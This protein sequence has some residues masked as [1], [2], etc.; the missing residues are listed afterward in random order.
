[1]KSALM[2]ADRN[3]VI[4][5]IGAGTLGSQIAFTMAALGHHEVRLFDVSREAVNNARARMNGWLHAVNT[6]DREATSNSDLERLLST[7]DSL[8]QSLESAELVIEAIPEDLEMKR[9]L[10]ARLSRLTPDAVL[11]TNS[12]SLKSRFL[13][14]VTSRP[15]RL[16]NLHFF[17]EPWKRNV[18]ELMTCGQTDDA[19]MTWVAQTMRSAGLHPIVVK[20]ESTG[21]L[22]NRIWRAVKREVLR[23]IAEDVGSPEDIDRMWKVIFEAPVGPCEMMDGIGLDVVLAIER[24]YAETNGDPGD[25]PPAF[26]QEWVKSGRL[27]KKAGRGFFTYPG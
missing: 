1:M 17:L 15:D 9:S 3:C 25:E 13:A 4:A 14:D 5:V 10:F 27:G 24:L 26:L 22:F 2:N 20:H 19:I 8:E 16:L 23:V 21:F 18:V 6:K 11:A 12:S 7:P